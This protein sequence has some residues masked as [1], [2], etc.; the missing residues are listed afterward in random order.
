MFNLFKKFF[1]P[2]LS[3]IDKMIQ[4]FGPSTVCIWNGINYS[5][6]YMIPMSGRKPKDWKDPNFQ[7]IKIGFGAYFSG[8]GDWAGGF[9]NES[10]SVI[11]IWI[12]KDRNIMRVERERP[13]ENGR[14]HLNEKLIDKLYNQ[15]LDVRKFATANEELNAW[16]QTYFDA[17]PRAR[18]WH[19]CHKTEILT[20][21]AGLR[22]F[23]ADDF[24]KYEEQ[25]KREEEYIHHLKEEEEAARRRKAEE[26]T[27]KVETVREAEPDIEA[28]LGIERKKEKVKKGKR[29]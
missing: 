26:P 6:E 25:L 11:G 22:K 8:S 5:Q 17:T 3:V 28:A 10:C 7:W 20:G 19:C 13:Y 29:R 9:T 15:L 12:D 27:A 2:K 14:P 23:V 4:F 1:G 24:V 18:Y 16:I 21:N